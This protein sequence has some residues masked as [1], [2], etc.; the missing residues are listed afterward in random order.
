[1]KKR[2]TIRRLL[3][4]LV[5][6]LMLANCVGE[7]VNT[8]AATNKRPYYIKINRKQNCITVYGLDDKGKYTVPVKAMACSVGVN[9]A[10]PTGTFSI[11]SK[12]RWHELM[13]GVYGQYC[14]RIVGGVLFHS[15]Y[16]SS[17]DPST[18]SY[19][20]YNRLGTAASHGCVR[21]NVADA[22]WIYDN[23]PSGTK[24]HIYDGKDAG[25]LGKPNPVR[26]DTSSRYRG[27]DPTDPNK[28]NPWR[29]MKPTITGIKNITVERCAKMPD[30]KKGISAR[31]YKG[32]SLK[33]SVTGKLNMKKSGKYTI[34]YKSTDALG[35]VTVKKRTITVKD[36][37]K[38]TVKAKKSTIEIN[39]PLTEKQLIALL[40]K[41]V[42]A[43]DSGETL[44]SKYVTVSATKLLD[45]IANG[46][47]GTYTVSVYAKDVAGNKS[48]KITFKVK[49]TKPQED[50]DNTEEGTEDGTEDGTEESGET[51]QNPDE[52]NTEN[53]ESGNPGNTENIN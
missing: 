20:A 49:Y 19:N 48:A 47:D 44:S 5:A 42:T 23:C 51:T 14:S 22:K 6:V 13:G 45:A 53:T 16:Y 4:A 26:I 24:I 2:S 27:W 52:N 50:T 29:K 33:I 7:T 30:L 31:D 17:A 18:L 21:L 46:T 8:S 25:P 36:T 3:C 9:N 35:N 1:M 34:S 37:K 11:S 28:Y 32:K 12:Y 15:V 41:N 39:E 43:K 10:T 40:K 38:P